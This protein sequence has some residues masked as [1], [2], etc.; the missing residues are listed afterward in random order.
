MANIVSR[1]LEG[2]EKIIA[3]LFLAVFCI[4]AVVA[5]TQDKESIPADNTGTKAPVI[6]QKTELSAGETARQIRLTFFEHGLSRDDVIE[7]DTE[8][9]LH[10]VASVPREKMDALTQTISSIL[11]LNYNDTV[12]DKGVF[13][14]TSGSLR[15]EV[16]LREK[17]TQ[18][19]PVSPIKPPVTPPAPKGNIALLIDDCGSNLE[20]ARRLANFKVPVAMA[21]L[22]HQIYSRQTAELAR[23]RGKLVWLHYPMEPLSYPATD[24]G[25]GAA[26]VNMPELLI[27]AVTIKNVENLG[28]ID[29][30]N[31]HMGSAFTEDAVKM[32]QLLTSIAPYTN[33]FIDSNT[34]PRTMAYTVCREN[35]DFKCGLNKKFLDNENNAAYIRGKLLE[36]AESARTGGGIIVIGHLRHETISV[37]EEMIPRLEAEGIS[38]VP[39]T[40]LM[41]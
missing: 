2:P 8:G 36:A 30:I 23:S 1:V 16:E 37:L 17:G 28:K 29:G 12:Y 38:F 24:P 25:E 11:R 19:K 32:R 7:T 4:I 34:S 6:S 31:N 9:L 10:I 22:P 41:H 13:V 18:V 26:L 3:V 21:I 20:L 5:L 40:R 39:V 14:A 35:T 33:N 15:L 27:E